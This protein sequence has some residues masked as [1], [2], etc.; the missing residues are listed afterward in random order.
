MSKKKTPKKVGKSEAI[1]A[2]CLPK[3][4]DLMVGT[5]PRCGFNPKETLRWVLLKKC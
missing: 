2:L 4:E 5:C 1:A 3:N